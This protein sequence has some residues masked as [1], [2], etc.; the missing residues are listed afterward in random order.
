VLKWLTHSS[1]LHPDSLHPVSPSPV[2]A[3][4]DLH[5]PP[6]STSASA[7]PTFAYHPPSSAP[8]PARLHL[9]RSQRTIVRYRQTPSSATV[10]PKFFLLYY[11]FVSST[12]YPL[13]F[14]LPQ[15]FLLYS[16]S[17]P[18]YNYTI[19]GYAQ[20]PTLASLSPTIVV[21]LAAAVIQ[22]DAQRWTLRSLLRRGALLSHHRSSG[23]L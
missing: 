5:H 10:F 12:F 2:A 8:P 6:I 16:P 23:P 18:H 22:F 20:R 19:S 17:I 21:H 14:H 7:I 13:I 4:I 9:R 1:W 3:V 11:F 15:R